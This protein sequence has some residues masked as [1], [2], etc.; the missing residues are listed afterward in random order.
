MR[1]AR[2]LSALL[3]ML[4]LASSAQA[5]SSVSRAAPTGLRGFL[6]RADEPL[7]HEYARTPAFA[8][9]PVAGATRYDFQL[10]MSNTFRDNG[11]ILS[12]RDLKTPVVSVAVTLP[13]ITGEPYSLYARVRGVFANGG[14]TRWSTPFGFNMRQTDVPKPLPSYPGLLRWT[15]VDGA[16]AYEVRFIDIP[17]SVFTYS[18][19]VDE[20]E[21]YTLHQG[22]LWISKVRWRIRALRTDIGDSG[23]FRENG[24]PVVQYGPWSPVYESVN[25]PFAVGPL[26]GLA[27][28]SD[29]VSTGR[30]SDSAHRFMPAFVFTGNQTFGATTAELYRVHVFTDEDCINRVYSSA[31]VGSPAYAPRPFGPLALPKDSTSLAAMRSQYLGD[32]DQGTSYTAD[33][34]PIVANESLPAATPTSSLA[35]GTKPSAPASTAPSQT[36]PAASGAGGVT[37]FNVRGEIGA[38]VDLWDT[39]WPQ[40]GYYW[41][42]VPVEAVVPAS[43]TTTVNEPGADIGSTALPVANAQGFAT[44]DVIAVGNAS[45]RETATVRG[46]NGNVLT[47]ATAFKI[48]HGIGE[49]VVRVS[50]NLVYRDAEL[51]Q[52]VCK[53][54]RFLRFGKSSEPTLVSAGAP[55]ASGLS[56]AGRLTAAS[57]GSPLFYGA[58]LVAWTPA[59]GADAYHI[60]WSKT[61]YPFRPQAVTLQNGST[62]GVLTLGTSSVLPLAP[63][64]WWYRVRGISWT[65]PSNAQFM[66]WSEPTRIVVAKPKV[67]VGGGR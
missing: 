36:A 15:P 51:P 24:V 4:V 62:D 39:N 17:K 8:W 32:G 26:N 37:F 33:E 10:S 28:V 18:N 19:V 67:R 1:T 2:L 41:T 64:T 43:L 52:D 48:A 58:P 3:A 42:V 27:T 29:V 22:P 25:P 21:F 34:E 14:A 44:G 61:R 49:P 6:F 47:L 23:V 9:R 38:P 55:F 7:R 13:W 16:G 53:Q 56:P 5:G 50:G 30:S 11:I 63:G 31:I 20:R 60:Q 35:G 66:G 59:L 45:N 12:R 57:A 40:G 54:G 46:V 65:L